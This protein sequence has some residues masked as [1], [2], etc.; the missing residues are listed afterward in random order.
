M[1]QVHTGTYVALLAPEKTDYTPCHP[2]KTTTYWSI[3]Y[4]S[5][6]SLRIRTSDT[7]QFSGKEKKRNQKKITEKKNKAK[8]KGK[9]KKRQ[10]KT[11]NDKKR[12]QGKERKKIQH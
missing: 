6:L 1:C 4:M 10:E 9:D 3:Y 11:R 5:Y 7:R 2:E 8:R 12:K